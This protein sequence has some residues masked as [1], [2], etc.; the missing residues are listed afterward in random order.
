[1]PPKH[2]KTGGHADSSAGGKRTTKVGGH[3]KGKGGHKK[4]KKKA[5]VQ[6]THDEIEDLFPDIKVRFP[7]EPA[8]TEVNPDNENSYFHVLHENQDVQHVDFV[9]ED[10]HLPNGAVV[11]WVPSSATTHMVNVPFTTQAEK[12][13]SYEPHLW[14]FQPEWIEWSTKHGRD[15]ARLKDPRLPYNLTKMDRR[16]ISRCYQMIKQAFQPI[17][18]PKEAYPREGRKVLEGLAEGK[19]ED[20]DRPRTPG[21]VADAAKEGVGMALD[22][23]LKGKENDG[24]ESPTRVSN[25]RRGRREGSVGRPINLSDNNSSKVEKMESVGIIDIFKYLKDRGEEFGEEGLLKDPSK[26]RFLIHLLKSTFPALPNGKFS[27]RRKKM[28]K[29]SKLAGK[30]IPSQQVKKLKYLINRYEGELKELR[31]DDEFMREAVMTKKVRGD[32][33][34]CVYRLS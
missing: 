34:Q 31:E 12:Q 13:Q 4:V 29:E 32:K 17:P 27:I 6:E 25:K 23:I 14:R 5:A 11:H 16:S 20:D 30:A 2:K 1:M 28:D 33:I 7:V 15:L 9:S 18:I 8:E 10:K 21:N 24:G 19:D 3:A 26:S 22:E